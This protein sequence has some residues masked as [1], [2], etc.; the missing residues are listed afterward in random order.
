MQQG[1]ILQWD[2]LL[3]IRLS[4]RHIRAQTI[5]S[6]LL[7]GTGGLMHQGGFVIVRLASSSRLGSSP[8]SCKHLTLCPQ[9]VLDPG[10]RF[11]CQGAQGYPKPHTSWTAAPLGTLTRGRHR[12]SND[13]ERCSSV[14]FSE[15]ENNA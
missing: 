10:W 11:A 9:Q 1:A 12:R 15:F 8:T 13:G 3:L 6:T 7:R 14:F 5:A 2:I 4:V